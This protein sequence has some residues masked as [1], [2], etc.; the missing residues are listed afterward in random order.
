MLYLTQRRAIRGE[1][2]ASFPAGQ[3]SERGV[4]RLFERTMGVSDRFGDITRRLVH[5]SFLAFSVSV[6]TSD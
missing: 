6:E 1:S 4:G 3:V 5:V 2:L